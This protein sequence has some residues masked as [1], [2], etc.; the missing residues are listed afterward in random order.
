M[1]ATN[2]WFHAEFAFAEHSHAGSI[3]PQTAV[4]N[5]FRNKKSKSQW[6]HLPRGPSK[7]EQRKC[8]PRFSITWTT[9]WA[10]I[11]VSCTFL[12]IIVQDK[13]RIHALIRFLLA[14]TDTKIYVKITHY[15]PVRGHYFLPND[16]DFGVR[17]GKLRSAMVFT[18]L[19]NIMPW[20]QKPVQSFLYFCY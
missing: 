1:F 19:S 18:F 15:F 7:Q 20:C 9:F 11:S 12:Q 2:F 10:I 3:L 14:L 16:Q 6:K 13:I 8:V 17:K 5:L 4:D